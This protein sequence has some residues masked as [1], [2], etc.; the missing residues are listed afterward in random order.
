[1]LSYACPPWLCPPSWS[2]LSLVSGLVSHL[3]WDAVSAWSRMLCLQ[4]FMGDLRFVPLFGV[5]GGVIF[6][7]RKRWRKRNVGTVPIFWRTSIFSCTFFSITFLLEISLDEGSGAR[8]HPPLLRSRPDLCCQRIWR[9]ALLLDMEMVIDVGMVGSTELFFEIIWKHNCQLHTY[10]YIYI[11]MSKWPKGCK[12]RYNDKE[13][14]TNDNKPI[15]KRQHS[16]AFHFWYKRVLP[17]AH[18][19]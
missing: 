15:R 19:S 4:N 1:M 16:G 18:I 8:N 17:P 11:Y 9:K 14:N 6:C 2:C 10:T 7:W 3:G 13:L 12:A 5:Y